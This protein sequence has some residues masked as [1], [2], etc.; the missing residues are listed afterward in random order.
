VAPAFVA[1]SFK[2]KGDHV[3]KFTI[4]NESAAIARIT[5]SGG[6]NFAVESL[7]S[8]GSLNDLLVNTIG[9]YRGTVLFDTQ[10]G[11][12]SVAFKITSTGSWTVTVAPV[13]DAR[14]WNGA[15]ALK[16]SGD[17]VVAVVPAIS[18]LVTVNVAYSGADNFAVTAYTSSDSSLLVNTI[19]KFSG[20]EQLPDGT[21]VL[22]V[23]ASGAWSMAPG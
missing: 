17:D 14:V 12:H 23:I 8:S 18:G 7:D 2:G 5:N 6:E 20:Q 21:I 4:P 16:G 19:G 11:S 9:A 22:D 3:A 1:Q 15:S 13:S 10:A